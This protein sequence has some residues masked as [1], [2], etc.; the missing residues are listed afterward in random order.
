MGDAR[1]GWETGRCAG[2]GVSRGEGKWAADSGWSAQ[3][4][5]RERELGW[6]RLLGSWAG[7]VWG[8]GL[9]S[10]SISILF[11]TQAQLFEF[12]R[13]LNSNPY[14]I[15]QLKQ[16]ISMNA[17]TKLNLRKFLIT[18]ETKARLNARLTQ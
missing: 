8:L 1:A 9:F 7:L 14:E 17:L 2:P 5:E 3:A 18:C 6:A 4:R 12:K 16:C 10:I 15:K 11:L 13:N